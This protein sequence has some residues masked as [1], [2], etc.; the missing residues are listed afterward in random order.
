MK[1]EDINIDKDSVEQFFNS[2]DTEALAKSIEAS[3]ELNMSNDNKLDS[4]LRQGLQKRLDRIWEDE[5]ELRMQRQEVEKELT[6]TE[7][8]RSDEEF[9]WLKAQHWALGKAM[10]ALAKQRIAIMAVLDNPNVFDKDDSSDKTELI[11]KL[12]DEEFE[13]HHKIEKLDTFLLD[14]NKTAE[15]N[16]YQLELL[17]H[18]REIMVEYARTLMNRIFNLQAQQKW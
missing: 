10:D 13:L 2:I 5:V 9:K 1:I 17:K 3:G 12:K 11:T 14:D 15:V 4:K 6:T 7:V 8:G 18:Q 16:E